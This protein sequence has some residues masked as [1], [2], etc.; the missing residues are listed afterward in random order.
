M[1]KNNDLRIWNDLAGWRDCEFSERLAAFAEAVREDQREVCATKHETWRN[2]PKE[3]RGDA[4][5][6]ILD[7]GKE[8]ELKPGMLVKSKRNSIVGVAAEIQESD[9]RIQGAH[10]LIGAVPL[11]KAEIQEY[12]DKAPD[13]R[14]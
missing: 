8:P 6:V 7:A 14:K 12:M 5:P 9:A 11:T 3:T 10:W 13:A 1:S 2:L 4:Y